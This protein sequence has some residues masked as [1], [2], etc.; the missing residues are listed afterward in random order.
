MHATAG[1]A[2]FSDCC[3]PSSVT[4]IPWWFQPPACAP[5]RWPGLAVQA[6]LATANGMLAAKAYA[7]AVT[8]ALST[9]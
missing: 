5:R 6:G 4:V 9:R 3:Q 2:M 1:H 8:V 7:L